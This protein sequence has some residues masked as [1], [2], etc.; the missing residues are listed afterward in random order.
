MK[1][2]TFLLGLLALPVQSQVTVTIASPLSGSHVGKIWAPNGT[3]SS[4]AGTIP[5]TFYSGTATLST[6][7]TTITLAST[8]AP[9]NICS[10]GLGQFV[11]GAGIPN[12]TRLLSCSSSTS[13]VIS[14]IPTAT[15]SGVAVTFFHML[16]TIDGG[17]CSG[18]YAFCYGAVSAPGANWRTTIY[19]TT[20]NAP[21]GSHT[22][23]FSAVD[24]A[25]NLGST[26]IPVTVIYSNPDCSMTA[27]PGS[28]YTCVESSTGQGGSGVVN[29]TGGYQAGDVIIALSMALIPGNPMTTLGADITST[30]QTALTLTQPTVYTASA[31][32]TTSSKTIT[33]TGATSPSD[34][35]GS[36]KGQTVT[37][38]GI[39]SGTVVIGCAEDLGGNPISTQP[40]LSKFPTSNSSGVSLS[41][42]YSWPATPFDLAITDTVLG[43]HYEVVTVTA[44][45]APSGGLI[46]GTMTRGTVS[47]G[48]SVQTHIAGN[49]AGWYFP[50]P[51]P[52]TQSML[53]STV[54]TAQGF[55]WNLIKV[56]GTGYTDENS[57]QMG[58]WYAVV[59]NTTGS[60]DTITF[61]F[62]NRVP[63]VGGQNFID[64]VVYRGLGAVGNQNTSLSGWAGLGNPSSAS[65]S[66][67]GTTVPG[68]GGIQDSWSVTPGDL[69][70]VVAVGSPFEPVNS[71][72]PLVP[73]SP[74][75]NPSAVAAWI[76]RVE[77]VTRPY[78]MLV[79]AVATGTKCN[80]GATVTPEDGVSSL[81][82]AFHA[83]GGSSPGQSA[84]VTSSNYLFNT[85]PLPNQ[86][87]NRMEMYVHDWVWGGGATH[88]L[89]G[90]G[91]F[92]GST[93]WDAYFSSATD[94]TV[95]NHWSIGTSLGSFS[96]LGLTHPAFY[97]RTQHIPASLVDR[98]EAFDENNSSFYSVELPYTSESNTGGTDCWLGNGGTTTAWFGWARSHSTVLPIGSKPPVTVDNTARVWELKLDGNLNDASGNGHGFT[99]SGTA[100]YE[101]TPYRHTT[102]IITTSDAPFWTNVISQR[103][104][105]P[106]TLSCANSVT[107]NDASPNVS[108][109]WQRLSGPSQVFINDRNSQLPTL[110]GLIFG[111]Y[112]IQLTATDAGGL[113]S[114]V[115]EHIGVVSTDN[116]YVVVNADPNVD[117]LF[118]HMI[119]WGHNPWGFAD[120]FHKHASDL[121]KAVYDSTGWTNYQWEK[122]AS[123]TVSY[124]V[125]GVGQNAFNHVGGTT[126]TSGINATT[127]AIPVADYTA[128]DFSDLPT[129]VL[130][131][132]VFGTNAN[133][134]VRICSRTITT[135]PAA[136]LN[137]CYDGRGAGYSGLSFSSGTVIG[138]NRVA[139][140]GTHF[141][142][143]SVASICPLG[144][145]PVGPSA[146]TVG[147]TTVTLTAGSPTMTGAGGTSWTSALV[148][149]WVRVL[150]THGTVPFIFV[151]QI[152]A[153]GTTSITLERNFPS[154]A[155][156]A[157]GLSY[158]ITDTSR[159]I[160]LQSP[161]AINLTDTATA[162]LQKIMWPT[163][164]CET[165]TSA[166]INIY[167]PGNSFGQAHDIPALDGSLQA[168]YTYSI[169]DASGAYYNQSV[170]GGL[171]FYS[172]DMAHR[173]L[174]Y[175]SGLKSAYDAANAISDHFAKSPWNY[176]SYGGS[177]LFHGGTGIGAIQ[178]AVL[179]NS[180]LWPHIRAYANIGADNITH[181]VNGGTPFC[182]YDDSR[183]LG[184]AYSWVFLSAIFDPTMK[185]TWQ[186]YLPGIQTADATCKQADNSWSDV[187]W[188]PPP[189]PGA[190][191]PV[192]LTTNQPTVAGTG[193]VASN[194]NGTA[195]G[196]GTVTVNGSVLSV[197]SGAIPVPPFNSSGGVY[198]TLA[199]T[200]TRGGNP[201]TMYA[202]YLGSGSSANLSVFWL[203]DAGPVTWMSGVYTVFASSGYP[204]VGNML[205]FATAITDDVSTKDSFLCIYNSPTSLTLDRPWKGSNGNSYYSY[206]TNSSNIPIAGL[207]QQ[208][209]MLDIRGTVYNWLASIPSTVSST[210]K[211]AYSTYANAI[212]T[213]THDV[214][215]D[216]PTSA[217]NYGRGFSFCEPATTSTS[218]AFDLRQPGCNNGT[219]LNGYVPSRQLNT[220]AMNMLGL[221]YRNN[222]SAPNKD[223]V[224]KAYGAV[225]GSQQYNTGGAFWDANTVA[226]N[227]G[228]SNF[229][230]TSIIQGKYFGQAAG[231]GFIRNWPAERLGGVAS[232]IIRTQLIGCKISSIPNASECAVI[233]TSPTSA[234]STFLC[235]ST[236][237]PVSV[238]ARTGAHLYRIDYQNSSHTVLSSGD[239]VPLPVQ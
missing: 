184:Y 134:E 152:H 196:T 234:S 27:I 91:S 73:S 52:T 24:S 166:Y 202:Q 206:G 136:N 220:E 30:G 169:T 197:T 4:T 183:D 90:G 64:V 130:L 113:S 205:T 97:L 8:T 39:P 156:T 98:I 111:D 1:L 11:T 127:L 187:Y 207:G 210:V 55:T 47:P 232:P 116:N 43:E 173:S 182:Y 112:N 126:I 208:P 168:G 140:T 122:P 82:V 185:A 204:N 135:P 95:Y 69:C 103:A 63:G 129:R 28:S 123:G 77:D 157:S 163:S 119:A 214:G 99:A 25:G 171:N 115:T 217:L 92:C 212:S 35:C 145:G 85:A 138:Q 45:N 76:E 102:A 189:S 236:P 75:V 161:Y 137:V 239:T 221:W 174:Y 218:T 100:S 56:T 192:T 93:G 66:S 83:P 132:S 3:A 14:Q 158:A 6:S 213:W 178:R 228:A 186:S 62:P 23:A 101:S 13:L 238:D 176:A 194:C 133:E 128:L 199:I 219:S 170:T 118:G 125:N 225:W 50:G 40:I 71:G 104:G 203:G 172:E 191:G 229:G 177:A 146:Y 106:A 154:D 200:G 131:G 110:S 19:F 175:S 141:L 107:Q 117:N 80:G 237:C 49:R 57:V 31:T 15:A 150:A 109:F 18:S 233:I 78:S 201:F 160:V 148:G 81:A 61:D 37:G 22:L 65:M 120:K 21:S 124:Y 87:S 46:T 17:S 149:S 198:G 211:N 180:S 153:A 2:L 12:N 9:S 147:S 88:L 188:G 72:T 114:T 29:F 224:D 34:I 223:F 179:G 33:L 165:E 7:S 143:D 60:A 216:A 164:G 108:C 227:L 32:L 215:M 151:A 84:Q 51:Q 193:F 190:F 144:A 181:V 74:A 222:P 44:L 235:T 59:T 159:T 167:N 54:A 231:M 96:T 68:S 42:S 67:G 195:S 105:Y 79:D 53:T 10:T 48:S 142:T 36:R 121:R 38:T 139:G 155:D 26:S 162:D 20:G 209:F 16:Y 86:A 230:D 58:L 94:V 226:M 70:I 89:Y 41:I 5:T